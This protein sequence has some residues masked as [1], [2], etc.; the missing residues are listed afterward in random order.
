M[1]L[2]TIL[3]KVRSFETIFDNSSKWDSHNA[4][5]Y[6]SVWKFCCIT[7]KQIQNPV[8]YLRWRKFYNYLCVNLH[9][10]CLTGNG[11]FLL[12]KIK[13]PN[14][15]NSS[16]GQFLASSYSSRYHYILKLLTSWGKPCKSI[17]FKLRLWD[18][19]FKQ[20]CTLLF[21]VKKRYWI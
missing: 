16:P 4:L 7:Q 2:V 11:T 9:L 17:S 18:V 20:S 13:L 6:F 8:S 5:E 19:L 14:L 15:K 10:R 12:P 21:H 3:R 1:N